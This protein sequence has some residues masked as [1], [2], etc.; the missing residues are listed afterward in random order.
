[1]NRLCKAVCTFAITLSLTVPSHRGF[2]QTTLLED[3]QRLAPG[4]VADTV[5]GYIYGYPLMMFGVTGRIGN[6]VPDATTKLGGAPLNQF[7]K[8]M[9]LPD[10]TFTAVVLPSTSTLYASSF[11]NLCQEPVILHIPNMNGRFFILQM[12]DG[13]TE[14]SGQSPGTRLNSPAGDYVLVGP[15]CGT[16][17]Q[18]LITGNFV[19]IIRMPT[20]SMWIIGRIY[21]NGSD[22]DIEYIKNSIYPGLTLTPWS[23]YK[24]GQPYTPP[25]T[26]STQPYGDVV[27]P[28]VRQVDGMEA[29]A[30]FGNL[31]S[32]LYYNPPVKQQDD[33]AVLALKRLGVVAGQPFDCTTLRDEKLNS[34]QQGL[35]LAKKIL[36]LNIATRPTTTGWTVSLDVGNYGIRYLLRAEVAKEAL[37]ANRAVD[38][39]YGYTQTDGGGHALEGSKK[40][41]IHFKKPGLNQGIP[42]VSSEAFWSLTI[43]DSNGKLVPSPD[44]TVKWNAV[45]MPMVQNHPAC[46]NNDGSLDIYLQPTTPTDAQQKCNWLPTPPKNGYIAFLRLYMP[47]QVVLDG[48]WVPPAIGSN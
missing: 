46:P 25:D 9:V 37:G 32:M 2:G 29:C 16:Y 48:N 26:L 39:V 4:V 44:S 36:D 27:T 21:T 22:S 1:M 31:A 35:V 47:D 13:W 38:A 17:K 10:A 14:V 30:F 23:K 12:L 8:E 3:V 45:G 19:D 42:P 5:L 20:S 7:G 15:D 11:L 28:P 18:P 6:N 33:L 41:V 24:Q 34:I 40:Y 43:Y